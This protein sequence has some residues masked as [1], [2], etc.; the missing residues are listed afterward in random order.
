MPRQIF[1]G[2]IGQVLNFAGVMDGND[3]RMLQPASCLSLAK[4][5]IP[6]FNEL[7]VLEFPGQGHGLD[8]DDPPDFGIHAEI[9]NAHGAPAKFLPDLITAKRQA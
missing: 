6:D 8:G 9:N 5:P 2:D 7:R 3:M 4:K 1:H